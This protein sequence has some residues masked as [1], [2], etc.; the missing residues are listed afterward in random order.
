MAIE[1]YSLVVHSFNLVNNIDGDNTSVRKL[2]LKLRKLIYS[3]KS[4]QIRENDHVVINSIVLFRGKCSKL[5]MFR[6]QCLSR[7]ELFWS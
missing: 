7:K 3:S 5:P 4:K 6:R 1:I 2:P